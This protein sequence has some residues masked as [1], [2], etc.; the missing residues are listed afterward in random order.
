[1]EAI[2]GTGAT[3]LLPLQV[4]EMSHAEF[5][6]EAEYRAHIR[7]APAMP[8]RKAATT[9]SAL[10]D[11]V[12]TV[13][14]C[15]IHLLG[16]GI[17]HPRAA[18]LLRLIRR[19]GPDTT[20]SMDSNRIRAVAGRSRSLTRVESELRAD[21]TEYVYGEVDSAVLSLTGEMLDY[22]DLVASPS[23]WCACRRTANN[24]RIGRSH[25]ARG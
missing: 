16:M 4:G 10:I 20:I 1:M 8:M 19:F 18:K 17:D 14:P 23:L 2:A 7:L 25:F 9:A 15:H 24:R 5:L 6:A 13:K 11:F 21:R 12:T 3:F 22:T